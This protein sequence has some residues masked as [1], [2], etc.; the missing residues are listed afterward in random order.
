MYQK[1]NPRRPSPA[2]EIALNRSKK[3][4]GL[5]GFYNGVAIKYRTMMTPLIMETED[6][7]HLLY[8]APAPK[9]K[10]A[11]NVR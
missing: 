11:H 7:A 1:V 2:R 3:L 6:N 9:P 4:D 8:R 5:P 10:K